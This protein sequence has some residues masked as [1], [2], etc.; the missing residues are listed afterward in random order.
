MIVL[1]GFCT[2]GMC[3]SFYDT[4]SN[5]SGEK[6]PTL[7]DIEDSFSGNLCRCTGYRSILDGAKKLFAERYIPQQLIADFPK[8]L[9]EEKGE[10]E[11]KP[12]HIKGN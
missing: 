11:R 1:D 9:E 3:M 10:C 7:N 6:Q 8:E 5:C 12:I 2:P 4:L